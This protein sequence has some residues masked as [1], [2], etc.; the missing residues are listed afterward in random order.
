MHLMLTFFRAYPWQTIIML[1]AL[2]LAGIAEGIGL[3]ALLP[4]LNIA[5]K[6]D[7]R[8]SGGQQ[9]EPPQNEFERLVTDTLN[10]LGIH[11]GIGA[12]LTI[13]VL[14]V[15]LKSLLLRLKT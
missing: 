15:T 10:D 14:G 11:P 2:L 1:V 8:Q 12:L 6:N 7:A 5:I 3:S 13:I 4:L 9:A